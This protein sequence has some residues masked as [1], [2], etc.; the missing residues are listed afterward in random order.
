M[1]GN[2]IIT[3]AGS[4]FPIE[5]ERTF[6]GDIKCP[7]RHVN[8]AETIDIRRIAEFFWRK[9]GMFHTACVRFLTLFLC[10]LERNNIIGPFF[11][12]DS[13]VKNRGGSAETAETGSCIVGT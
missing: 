13:A 8:S 12:T 5:R 3:A 1:I 10:L 11:V 2:N 6:L 7:V 9:N 4:L